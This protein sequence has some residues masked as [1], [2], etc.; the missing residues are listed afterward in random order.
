[1]RGVR[2]IITKAA[3][4]G[5]QLMGMLLFPPGCPGCGRAIAAI[6]TI[7][8]DCWLELPFLTP[9]FC[10][11]MGIPFHSDYGDGILS[12]EALA[13]P[14][15]FDHARAV[16]AHE[17]LARNLVTRL[18]YGARTDLA[19]WMATWMVRAGYDLVSACDMIVPVPL[20]R[21]RFWKRGYNQSAELARA[22]ARICG[23]PFCPQLL[24]RRKPTRPQVGLSAKRRADNVRGVFA[25]P[26]R[27]AAALKHKHI[28]L[29]D[30]VYTTGATVKAAARILK[31]AGA[32]RV[33]VLTFSRVVIRY[34]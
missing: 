31:R 26:P 18:K 22:I 12:G 6:G 3:A 7:C 23:K 4:G 20:H 15:P 19:P 30:D 33:D 13:S 27:G 29:V 9:P 34:E 5:V 2:R 16:V 8:S 17:G 24:A 28:V 1:M 21:R 11:V 25:V 10:P 32:A 14:P